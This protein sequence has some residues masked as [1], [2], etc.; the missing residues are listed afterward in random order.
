MRFLFTRREKNEKIGI[1][2]EI[3]KTW[4]WLIRPKTG[5]PGFIWLSL[6]SAR[7]FYIPFIIYPLS[8]LLVPI[9]QNNMDPIMTHVFVCSLMTISVG[10]TEKYF[11]TLP[12]SSRGK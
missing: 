5:W 12:K 1:F 3:F 8:H 11:S 9:F 4:R 10:R 2:G 6:I 7:I